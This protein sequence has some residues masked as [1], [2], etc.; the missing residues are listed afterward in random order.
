LN[1]LNKVL[2]KIKNCI[3]KRKLNNEIDKMWETKN[4]T[5]KLL[6]IK[7]LDLFKN[8]R[9]INDTDGILKPFYCY[10]L[11]G[12]NKALYNYY[13]YMMKI[14]NEVWKISMINKILTVKH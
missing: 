12:E 14:E 1:F 2:K 13:D 5:K 9:W 11:D 6:I 8:I 3:I 7:P 10:R 4:F